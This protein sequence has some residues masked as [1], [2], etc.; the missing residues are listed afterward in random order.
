[1]SSMGDRELEDIYKILEELLDNLSFNR[2]LRRISE[3]EALKEVGK[4]FHKLQHLH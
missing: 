4:R 3:L 2:E 1:M